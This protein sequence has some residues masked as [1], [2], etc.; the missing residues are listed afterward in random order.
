MLETLTSQ[1]ELSW[2]AFYETLRIPEKPKAIR[3]ADEALRAAAA[4]RAQGQTRH[5]EAGQLLSQQKLGEAPAITQTAVDAVGAELATLI[6]AE[7]A[8]H[9]VSRKA[10]KAYADTVVADLEEPLRRYRDAIEGQITAL[11]DLLAV[12]SVL[13]RDASAAGVR[14]PSKLPELCPTLLGQLKTMRTLMA[15]V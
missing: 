2:S 10:R 1:T 15:R 13:R 8:A 6:E 14:L 4:A 12:G 7:N 11:E 9:E 5:I 3:D